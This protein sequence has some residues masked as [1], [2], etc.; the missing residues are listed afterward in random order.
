ML[1]SGND[2]G[3]AT[4]SVTSLRLLFGPF[5]ARGNPLQHLSEERWN[6]IAPHKRVCKLNFYTGSA[7]LQ[8]TN[9]SLTYASVLCVGK[10]IS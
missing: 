2:N 4:C 6:I 5:L 8:P 7:W 10:A 3:H 1:V 9:C